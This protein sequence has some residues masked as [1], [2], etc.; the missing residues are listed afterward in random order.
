MVHATG[1]VIHAGHCIPQVQR[2]AVAGGLGGC[3]LGGFA[4]PQ[5][6]VAEDL[7]AAEWHVRAIAC[8]GSGRDAGEV[9]VH[10]RLGLR[11]FPF[12]EQFA[13]FRKG[14][15][16]ALAVGFIGRSGPDRTLVEDEAFFID[17]AEDHRAEAAVAKGSRLIKPQGGLVIPQGGRGILGG[18]RA[19]KDGK[20]KDAE[21]EKPTG[22]PPGSCGA[23]GRFPGN[24][25]RRGFPASIARQ[26][27]HLC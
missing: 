19:G 20:S 25:C 16:S 23:A 17:S 9:P 13:D 24:S 15:V 1:L 14:G 27:I 12:L 18:Q 21:H 10:Q 26:V 2:A 8:S 5:P 6:Q 11:V 4:E 3:V 22:K 7:V